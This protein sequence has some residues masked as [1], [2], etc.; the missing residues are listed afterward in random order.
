MSGVD[1][2]SNIDVREFMSRLGEI[3]MNRKCAIICVRH[4]GKG[5]QDKAMKKGLGS[6]D[7]VASR[8]ISLASRAATMVSGGSSCST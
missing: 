2:N 4:F 5:V 1:G 3:A 6:T 8:A 7:F